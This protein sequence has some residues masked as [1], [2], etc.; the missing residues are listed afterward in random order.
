[1]NEANL[2]SVEKEVAEETDP[3]KIVVAFA[4]N[5]EGRRTIKTEKKVCPTCKHGL[6]P[7]EIRCRD[8]YLVTILLSILSDPDHFVGK[9][10]TRNLFKTWIDRGGRVPIQGFLSRI[11]REQDSFDFAVR[12]LYDSGVSIKVI[13]SAFC[14]AQST[15]KTILE[16]ES[17]SDLFS[18]DKYMEE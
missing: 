5:L 7:M 11:I 6:D 13:A 9:K 1:M 12:Y 15:V 3:V 10:V 2:S 8:E 4:R 17:P 14:I 16:H 18:V